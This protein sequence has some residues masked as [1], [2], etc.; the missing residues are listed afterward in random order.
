VGTGFS[1]VDTNAYVKELD[2]MADQFIQFLE[3]WFALFPQYDRDD[4]S[5]YWPCGN[6][7]LLRR[8]RST[9]LASPMLDSTSP[10][11]P[12]PSSPATRRIPAKPGTSR[13]C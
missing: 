5:I 7:D 6:D 10:I 4:V 11:S 13:D 2:E 12:K 1:L 9:S 3:K 8:R